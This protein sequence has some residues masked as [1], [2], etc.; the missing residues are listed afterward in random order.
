[1][2]NKKE[3]QKEDPDQ[4]PNNK[5]INISILTRNPRILAGSG[6]FLF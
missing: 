6:P 5:I 4:K 2:K 3:I 1:M